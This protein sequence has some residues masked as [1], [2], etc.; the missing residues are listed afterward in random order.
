MKIAVVAV[1]G[2]GKHLAGETQ[3]AM[4]DLLLSLPAR[5]PYE[6]ARNYSEFVSVD[7]Q[8]PLQP[9]KTI[10][11]ETSA[12]QTVNGL[13][14][15]PMPD[16]P[17]GKNRLTN[18]YQ[19]PSATFAA[20]AQK[21]GETTPGDA[22]L[23]WTDV[24][25]RGYRGGQDGNVYRTARLEGK[26]LRDNAEVHIYEVLWA[27]LAKPNNTVITFFLSLF[28]LILHLASLSRVAIDTGAAEGKGR[29]WSAYRTV[30]RWA[31]RLLQAFIPP[32]ELLLLISLGPCVL[33]VWQATSGQYWTPIALGVLGAI[34]LGTV[35]ILNAKRAATEHPRVW[36]FRVFLLLLTGVVVPLIL[37]FL[38]HWF[39]PNAEM[40]KDIASALLF[41]LIP[42]LGLFYWI[43]K[44]YEDA[45]KGVSVT[46]MTFFVMAGVMFLLFLWPAHHSASK[47]TRLVVLASLWT[48]QVILCVIRWCWFLMVGCAIA[49]S[50]LGSI[51][52]RR[53]KRDR[54][55]GDQ[56]GRA[57]AAVRT[58]RLALALPLVSF[59][60]VTLMIWAA[61][62][63]ATR[64]LMPENEPIFSEAVVADA[65]KPSW[66]ATLEQ[67]RLVPPRGLTVRN[68]GF[69]VAGSKREGGPQNDYALR[70]FAWTMGYHLPFTLLF[71]G[72]TTFLLVWWV[73]PSVLSE[74]MVPRG[75]PR[76]PRDASDA[77]SLRMGTWMSRGLDATTVVT[78]LLWSAVFVLPWLYKL[79]AQKWPLLDDV[80][81]GP[82]TFSLVTNTLVGFTLLAALAKGGQTVLATLLDVDTYLRSTPVYATPRATIF[83]RYISTLRYLRSHGDENNP[84][85]DSI[86]IVAHSLGALISGDLLYYLQSERG[87]E[88]WQK[89]DPAEPS[90]SKFTS[91][92]ITLLTMGNPARQLLNRFFPYLYDWVRPGPD[93]GKCPLPAPIPSPDDSKTLEIK[94]AAPP[95]PADLGLTRWINA[96]RSGDYVGRSLWLNE[97]YHRP[98]YSTES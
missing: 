28:Q 11:L 3:N 32:L 49:A 77:V 53:M 50:L 20:R 87:K 2:V 16:S 80:I 31:V 44:Q 55:E 10:G 63:S 22:G 34:A 25:L 13:P 86:V 37:I 46:G 62:L 14:K 75:K 85:Y 72:L 67:V 92:P 65:I 39:T 93:N 45:R 4:V 94:D 58:S 8:I 68:K 95:D 41:W 12:A 42:G 38:L 88:E 18:L 15:P 81:F 61:F 66:Y 71:I 64:K 96:Y 78:L 98:A 35:W 9:V 51:A 69:E 23:N 74:S 59:L 5:G 52:W 48:G 76:A 70:V 21:D 6:L 17:A 97:W 83:E 82:L 54:P 73:L 84:G 7:L 36:A 89:P 43:L 19:E 56:W 26:R 29:V 30:Q 90:A 24:L 47:D 40:Q 1:H 57:R 27:D 60:L 91:I 33:E 79:A